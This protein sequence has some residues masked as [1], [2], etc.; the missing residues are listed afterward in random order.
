MPARLADCSS[1]G[2]RY[3][4]TEV[5]GS[6]TILPSTVVALR[7][8]W[9][10]SPELGL[11]ESASLTLDLTPGAWLISLQYFTPQGFTLSTDQGFERVFDPAI[12]G[13]RLSNMDTGSNGQFWP[14]GVIEV[15]KAGPVKLTVTTSEPTRL[16]KHS[17]YSRITKLGRLAARFDTGRRTVPMSQICNQW[18]D[19]FRRIPI[20]DYR[21]DESKQI[22]AEHRE[23]RKS[24]AFNRIQGTGVVRDD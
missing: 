20:S 23:V 18:V 2:G 8:E 11:G 19:F 17:G 12:D 4:S 7:D 22:A 9:S 6:A 5:E 16:Q 15:K 3:Y 21:K 14:A 13:Q 24:K 10:P 1:E